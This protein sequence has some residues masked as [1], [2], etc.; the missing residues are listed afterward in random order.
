MVGLG[1]GGLPVFLQQFCGLAV[2]TVELDPVVVQLAQAHFGF[3]QSP[4]LQ[5]GLPLEAV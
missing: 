4:M 3:V 5:V 2:Q 1:G